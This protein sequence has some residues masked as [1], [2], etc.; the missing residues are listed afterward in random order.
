MIVGDGDHP[1]VNSL[2]GYS[3]GKGYVIGSVGDLEWTSHSRQVCVVAQTTQ[4][5]DEYNDIIRKSKRDI[6]TPLSSIRSAT[7][8]K[9]GR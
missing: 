3:A 1:E 8:R 7:P 9:K 2:Q 4:S 6:P 5:V